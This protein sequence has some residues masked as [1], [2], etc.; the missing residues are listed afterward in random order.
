MSNDKSG[1][2][3]V[4][5]CFDRHRQSTVS[6]PVLHFS[7][8]PPLLRCFISISDGSSN[9]FM[10]SIDFYSNLVVY[11]PFNRFNPLLIRLNPLW[12]RLDFFVFTRVLLVFNYFAYRKGANQSQSTLTRSNPL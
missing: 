7:F 2:V 3:S 6:L 10:N 9:S 8:T 11:P 12:I 4:T 1:N 5:S